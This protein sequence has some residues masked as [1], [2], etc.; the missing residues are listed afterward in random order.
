MHA[1]RKQQFGTL[2]LGYCETLMTT[3]SDFY[4]IFSPVIAPGMVLHST[5][6]NQPNKLP[7]IATVYG[8]Q[9][10]SSLPQFSFPWFL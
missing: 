6:C 7:A 9:T 4:T 8:C 2:Y 10:F 5:S 1:L 3:S